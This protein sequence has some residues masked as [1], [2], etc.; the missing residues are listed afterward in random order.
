MANLIPDGVLDETRCMDLSISYACNAKCLFCSQ[1]FSWRK[2]RSALSFEQAARHVY[3]GYRQGYRKLAISGGDPTSVPFLEKIVRFAR[4]TGFSSIRLQTNGIRLADAE[5]ANRLMDAGL[6]T[7]KFSVHGHE[8]ELHDR[9]VAVPGAFE[10][11]L[12]A[13]R[14]LRARHCRLGINIVLNSENHRALPRFF[15]FFIEDVGVTTY[16]II[17]PLYS[18][19]MVREAG[20]IGLPLSEV[21]SSVRE[22]LAVFERLGLELPTLLHFTPCMLPGYEERMIGWHRYNA[23]VVEPDG[24]SRDLDATVK[25][26]KM[27][28]VSCDPCVYRGRCPG[29]DRQYAETFGAAEFVP[30]LRRPPSRV[31]PPS[32][33]A[34]RRVLTENER[35]VLAVLERGPLGTGELLAASRKFP[36]CQDCRGGAAILM[37]AEWLA[38]MG[39][40]R[41]SR[42]G[43][44]Y[45][46]SLAEKP[47]PKELAAALG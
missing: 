44:R 37:A 11:M 10:K 39:R 45:V 18:G 27:L 21:V 42:E 17:Y 28:P 33:D 9:L 30:V 25:R 35:C 12:R 7:V 13:I 6:T 43:S 38:T 1:E 26:H 34:R 20:R 22:G 19:N 3:A 4:G 36:L 24:S 40:V 46:W 5:Y 31:G 2:E 47:A 32:R 29:I 41:R 14:T 15:R 16:T 23:Q 8:P